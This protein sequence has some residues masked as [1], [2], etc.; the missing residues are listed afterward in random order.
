M[1]RRGELAAVKDSDGN[2]NNRIPFNKEFLMINA[3]VK[4]TKTI[5]IIFE[6]EKV[7]T[8]PLVMDRL[9]TMDQELA[10]LPVLV[11]ISELPSSAMYSGIRFR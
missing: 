4:V 3:D 8:V 1:S 6:Q 11:M 7:P 2:N 10:E 9:Y 5:T